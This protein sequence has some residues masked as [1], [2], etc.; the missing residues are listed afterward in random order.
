MDVCIC[1]HWS[2][3]RKE[4]LKLPHN[5]RSFVI[6]MYLRNKLN[7]SQ[8]SFQVSVFSG[9]W[10]RSRSSRCFH[11]DI[12]EVAAM[13][14]LV[15]AAGTPMVS[16]YHRSLNA[17]HLISIWQLEM[18]T[19]AGKSKVA[20]RPESWQLGAVGRQ[21]RTSAALTGNNSWSVTA[22]RSAEKPL[23]RKRRA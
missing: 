4:I 13:A 16:T 18:R 9:S 2:A 20:H 3:L 17:E 22:E 14:P 7:L 5:I 10:M 12:I 1:L 19:Y 8:K 23:V 15:A 11:T 21:P 6:L